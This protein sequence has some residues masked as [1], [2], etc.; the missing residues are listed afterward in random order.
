M[1]ALALTHCVETLNV[2]CTTLHRLSWLNL[3]SSAAALLLMFGLCWHTLHC[4]LCG[5]RLLFI[6]VRQPERSWIFS[7]AE[8]AFSALPCGPLVL[9]SL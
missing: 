4:V 9:S 8:K 2:L 6:P 3:V 1:A 5:V 7:A